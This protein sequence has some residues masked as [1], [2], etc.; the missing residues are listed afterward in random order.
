[1]KTD[2]TFCTHLEHGGMHNDTLE[3]IA[4]GGGAFV[5]ATVRHH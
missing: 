2:N 5:L 1:M 4:F 3:R